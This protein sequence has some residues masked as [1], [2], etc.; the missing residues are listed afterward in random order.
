MR[1]LETPIP[2]LLMPVGYPCGRRPV[3]ERQLEVRVKLPS[4]IDAPAIMVWAINE[5]YQRGAADED[6]AKEQA[7][8]SGHFGAGKRVKPAGELT[9]ERRV[10]LRV[11]GLAD[12]PSALPIF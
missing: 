2:P 8:D 3:Q 4:I 9:V 6:Y 12:E 10:R 5:R 1:W 11:E 7:I